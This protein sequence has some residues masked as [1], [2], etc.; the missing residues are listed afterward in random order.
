MT[1]EK[2]RNLL[3]QMF[4]IQFTKEEHDALGKAIEAITRQIPMKI[5]SDIETSVKAFD[6]EDKVEMFKCVP[7]SECGK[8]IVKNKSRNYCSNCGQAIDWSE[9]E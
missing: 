7:C 2:A 5:Q 9:V 4:L 8:W 6:G 1:Y 3:S